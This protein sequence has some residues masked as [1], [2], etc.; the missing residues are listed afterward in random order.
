MNHILFIHSSVEGHLGYSQSL[1]I[2]NKAI[3]S[4][5]EQA[6][7]WDAGASFGYTPGSGIAGS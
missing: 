7:L 3:I 4:I 2:M 5:G 1:A 6:A